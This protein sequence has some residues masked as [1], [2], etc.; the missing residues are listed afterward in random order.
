M[1]MPS[2]MPH[3][4]H[5]LLLRVASQH[6]VQSNEAADGKCPARRKEHEL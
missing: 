5:K 2:D 3:K 6:L 4:L 1:G